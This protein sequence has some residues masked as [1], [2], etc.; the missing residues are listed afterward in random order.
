MEYES[1]SVIEMRIKERLTSDAKMWA[2]FVELWSSE[3]EEFVVVV[4]AIYKF[5]VK[6]GFL[7]TKKKWLPWAFWYQ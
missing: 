7:V 5:M 6:K 4:E 3:W 1:L 2:I